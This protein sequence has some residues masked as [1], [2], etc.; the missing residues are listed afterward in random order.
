M[1]RG[2]GQCRIEAREC[3]LAMWQGG[4]RGE[5]GG[6]TVDSWLSLRQWEHLDAVRTIFF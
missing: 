3:R 5:W 1:S 4:G 6:R 2:A